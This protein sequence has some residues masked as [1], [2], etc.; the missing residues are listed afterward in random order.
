MQP[1]HGDAP[2]QHDTTGARLIGTSI[3]SPTVETQGKLWQPPC[4]VPLP[5]ALHSGPPSAAASQFLTQFF[6]PEALPPPLS[7]FQPCLAPSPPAVPSSSANG[8]SSPSVPVP[9]RPG[10]LSVGSA[11][12]KTSSS[13]Q[14]LSL[15]EEGHPNHL[16]CPADTVVQLQAAAGRCSQSILGLWQGTALPCRE[17][18]LP[19]GG[20]G[21]IPTQLQGVQEGMGDPSALSGCLLECLWQKN[22]RRAVG[23][24]RRLRGTQQG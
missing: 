9:A 18:Q 20:R 15:P 8:M 2:E 3:S 14:H 5:A 4:T 19:G 24:Q 6:R 22:L 17:Q 12:R 23:S 11:L 13:P 16:H 1:H 21:V 7:T 10:H